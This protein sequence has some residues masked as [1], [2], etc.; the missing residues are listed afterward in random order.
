[1]KIQNIMTPNVESCDLQDNLSAAAMVM[2]RLEGIVSMND[3]V[4]HTDSDVRCGP[5]D[6]SE[7][8]ELSTFRLAPANG[9]PARERPALR[10]DHRALLTPP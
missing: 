6:S 7:P 2:W 4:M 10:G 1:M 9:A 5:G 8:V 3:L